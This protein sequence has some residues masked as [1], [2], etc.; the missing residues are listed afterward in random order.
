MIDDPIVEDVYQA[1]QKILD[2][3]QGD[4]GKWL[5]HLR[6]AEACHADRVV[7]LDSMRTTNER[8]HSGADMAT[9][10]EKESFCG[11]DRVISNPVVTYTWDLNDPV[12][13]PEHNEA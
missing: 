13:K 8:Q 1:R 5:E 2:K 4:L 9:S 7:T 6:D 10:N 11:S 3:W 12:E